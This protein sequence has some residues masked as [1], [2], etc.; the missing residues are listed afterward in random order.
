MFKIINKQI[1]APQIKRLD[2]KADL[3]S[4]RVQAGQFVTVVPQEGASRV[5][6][7][8]IDWDTRKGTISVI[9]QEL[10]PATQQ[11][12]LIPIGEDIFSVLGPLGRPSV[13]GEEG[14]VVCVGTGAGTAQ[15][16][17]ICRLARGQGNKVV[18]VLG[19]RTRR[20]ILLESQMRMTCHNL[21]IA[22]EDGSFEKRGM[23]TD[24]LSAILAKEKVDLV[25]AVGSFEMMRTV[26]EMTRPKAIKTLI[27]TN[28]HI[29]CGMGICLSCRIKVGDSILRA[30]QEGPEFDAHAVDYGYLQ[31][32]LFA[33]DLR[34][35]EESPLAAL[36]NFVKEMYP[37]R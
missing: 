36:K 17:P 10:G 28:T 6:L 22:T 13:L 35:Q 8:V 23:A 14:L 2:I 1:L 9:F 5:P 16:L 31:E 27:Q 20:D 4:R 15:L 24:I 7:T 34:D 30:C 3:I 19:A 33:Y 18:G 32:R 21:R 29:L 25:Y 11:L 12:G 37:E 26:A